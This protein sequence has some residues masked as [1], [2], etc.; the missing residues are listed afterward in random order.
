[1]NNMTIDLIKS[2]PNITQIIQNAVLYVIDNQI[3]TLQKST[4]TLL[5]AIK[6][7]I[8]N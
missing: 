1:M 6:D 7:S 8:K 4:A 2:I 3:V 5:H